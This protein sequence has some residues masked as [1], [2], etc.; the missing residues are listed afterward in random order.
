MIHRVLS[1]ALI[2]IWQLRYKHHISAHHFY[3]MSVP[4]DVSIERVLSTVMSAHNRR[5]TCFGVVLLFISVKKIMGTMGCFLAMLSW[6]IWP[7]W[8]VKS[9]GWVSYAMCVHSEECETQIFYHTKNLPSHF[10]PCGSCSFRHCMVYALMLDLLYTA[11]LALHNFF[12]FYCIICWM[13]HWCTEWL[14]VLICIAFVS[15]IV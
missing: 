2:S 15:Y 6:D 12:F 1:Q 10:P 13:D 7:F 9:G 4:D 8:S 3:T 5:I 11:G 14:H